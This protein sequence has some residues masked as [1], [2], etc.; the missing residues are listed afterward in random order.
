MFEILVSIFFT[1][2][3]NSDNCFIDF[4]MN[5]KIILEF[6]FQV[7]AVQEEA[8]KLIVAYS[9]EKAQEI[10]R[11]ESEVVNAWRNLQFKLDE[12]KHLLAD[13]FDGNKFFSMVRD[14]MNWMNEINRQIL[15]TE[16]PRYVRHRIK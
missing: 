7:Q 1:L 8:A 11:R 16:K 2:K 10:Q 6:Y 13:S 3:F 12:R 4:S 14:L 9:G 15:G 5:W